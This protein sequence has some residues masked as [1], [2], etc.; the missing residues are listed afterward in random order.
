MKKKIRL[1]VSGSES[2]TIVLDSE[3]VQAEPPDQ[4]PR[5]TSESTPRKAD[6][7]SKVASFLH[8][9]EKAYSVE[10]IVQHTDL[11]MAE[12]ARA[13]DQLSEDQKVSRKWSQFCYRF[14][15]NS[16]DAP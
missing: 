2:Q 10:E 1:A 14:Y 8:K 7:K 16:D 15:W 6:A 5:Q 3:N 11:S 9:S 12:V 13:L 4:E